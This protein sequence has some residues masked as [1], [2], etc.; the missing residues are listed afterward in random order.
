MHLVGNSVIIV[1]GG[2][3]RRADQ[4]VSLRLVSR[5]IC[6]RVWIAVCTVCSESVLT[7]VL[8]PTED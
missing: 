1:S 8:I 5:A 4:Q 6:R 3:G 7:K 2:G